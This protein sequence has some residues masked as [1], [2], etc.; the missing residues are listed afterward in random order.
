MFHRHW[1]IVLV[2]MLFVPAALPHAAGLTQAERKIVAA[3]DSRQ[4]AALALLEETVNVQ[5][6]TENHAGVRATGA[7]YAREYR[8][9]GFETR[10]VDTPAAVG[11]AGHFVAEH[12]G[13]KGKP[14]V[15]LI[16]HLDTVLQQ[17]PFRREG[18]RAYGSGSADMKGG[19]LVA[20]EAVR[21][22]HE[23][24]ALRGMNVT[25]V[26][27]GDEEDPGD[28]ALA[29]RGA[30]L[31]A[32]R[33]SDIALAFEGAS[34]GKAVIGRRGIGQ[35]R[36]HVTGEQAHSSGIFNESR[37]FGA[38]YQAARVL[39]RFRTE[40]R[41]PNLT[42]NPSVIVGGTD[43]SYDTATKSGTARG[44]TNVIPRE[45]Y[46]E[47][48]V[49]YLSQAQFDAVKAKM[50]RIVADTLPHTTSQIEVQ[51]SYPSMAPTDGNRRVLGVL[52]SASRDL[53]AEAIVA[54]DPLERGAGDIAF[55][56]NDGRL[57]CLD[58][59]GAQG[60]GDHA[61]GE[62]AEIDSLRL[63]MQRAAL[64]LYRLTR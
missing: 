2:S 41:E 11:R 1:S 25:V 5:S 42:Y 19:N 54:Q 51:N 56:C 20:L 6:A 55:V 59:L 45:A 23:A 9:L 36:L 4:D 28:P 3:V 32:A 7:I 44:K 14:R 52:D 39:E 62:Y 13:R 27:T 31:E 64:L 22:L 26:Y 58:G 47:G 30:L 18:N 12:R 34:P 17:E 50:E 37:G 43:V 16:G 48:D 29:S 57:A 53:G 10:W 35:W 40:L 46:V 24:G 61:P 38:I 60:D 15:L 49:R 21:A 8:A 63:Q 33:H